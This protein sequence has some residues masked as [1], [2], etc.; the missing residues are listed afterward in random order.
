MKEWKLAQLFKLQAELAVF[1]SKCVPE[2]DRNLTSD[3]VQIELEEGSAPLSGRYAEMWN[4]A[5]SGCLAIINNATAETRD[6]CNWRLDKR[7]NLRRELE[8]YGVKILP[9]LAAALGPNHVIL[10]DIDARWCD[11][12]KMALDLVT[13]K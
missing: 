9:E 2:W 6:D 11:T 5:R 8:E 3:K 4:N 7:L 13:D 12:W 1:G 10:R